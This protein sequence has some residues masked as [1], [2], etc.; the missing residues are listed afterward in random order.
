MATYAEKQGISAFHPS[1]FRGIAW[2][3]ILRRVKRQF[4]SDNLS[5]VAAGVAFYALLAIVPALAAAVSVY[6]LVADPRD[7]ERMFSAIAGVM[8]QQAAQL[9]QTQLR[10]IV[11]NS[12]G[13]LGIG[14][15]VGILFS[16]WSAT[17]G[18]K[19]VMTALN[20]A[21]EEEEKR[22]FFRLNGAALFITFVSIVGAL[23]ALTLVVALPIL[24]GNLGMPSIVAT[25]IGWLRW[26]LLA[27]MMVVFLAFIYRYAP[28]RNEPRWEWVSWGAVAATVLWLIASGLFSWYVANFGSYN[29]TYG[30]LG[31]VIILLMWFYLSAYAVLVGAELNSEMEHQTAEDTTEDPS[32]PRGARGARMADTVAGEGERKRGK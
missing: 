14:A 6:G 25:V 7:V 3:D 28:S 4:S 1:E 19:S 31:A 30:A 21:Y 9:I 32:K 20:I 17:K 15:L 24:L 16:L 23:I 5:V 12:S 2:K 22:G 8:P 18:T 11:A 10:D 26:L 27:V 13:A 29:E